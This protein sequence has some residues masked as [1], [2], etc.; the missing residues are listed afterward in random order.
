[1]TSGIFNPS[2]PN[3]ISNQTN[4]TPSWT[5]TTGTSTSL[6]QVFDGTNF[7]NDSI[8][9]T[10]GLRWYVDL[11]G[12]RTLQYKANGDWTDIPIAYQAADI[13]NKL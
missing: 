13:V 7:G 12:N 1:M 8:I 3:D 6:R 11:D 10:A 2:W 9:T 5:V 4:I